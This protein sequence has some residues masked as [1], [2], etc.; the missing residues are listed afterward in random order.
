MFTMYHNAWPHAVSP[1]TQQADCQE[2]HVGSKFF[3]QLMAD[4]GKGALKALRE[5]GEAHAYMSAC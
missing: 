5:I 4:K 2:N 1:L 3:P